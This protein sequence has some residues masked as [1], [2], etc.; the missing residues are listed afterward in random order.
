MARLT[1]LGPSVMQLHS[2]SLLKV[3]FQFPDFTSDSTF[4]LAVSGGIDSMVMLDLFAHLSQKQNIQFQVAHI[5]H[6]IRDESSTDARFVMNYCHELDIDCTVE[7]VDVSAEMD[8]SGESLEMCARRLRYEVL[9][10][11]AAIQNLD[12]IC[13][14]HNANDEAET[15]LMRILS[16][17]GITGLQ[18][19]RHM[20]GTIIRPLLRFTREQIE[21]HATRFDVPYRE[22]A[23]NADLSILRNRIR[24]SLLPLLEEEY[25]QSVVDALNRLSVAQTEV[26]ELLDHA[27]L[28][29]KSDVV[30]RQSTQEIMLDIHGLR[31]YFTAIQKAIIFNC[32]YELETDEIQ[33]NFEQTEQL[34]SMI[35]SAESGIEMLLPG[36]IR[37]VVDRNYL[38]F[39]TV[40]FRKQFAEPFQ[41]DAIQF[42]GRYRIAAET[43]SDLT[44][45]VLADSN[46]MIAYFEMISI[47]QIIEKCKIKP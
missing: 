20:R 27:A 17:T 36:N 37:A 31:T 44:G 6:G 46:E 10:S 7:A 25:N 38:Y 21:A 41:N 45:E 16:G 39:T 19:I 40:N 26:Q 22:D 9:E 13:T 28:Q 11:I 35:Q 2:A 30:I 32:L 42:L 43:L 12:L 1:K 5:E 3:L 14:A 23:T 33:L 47:F 4:L 24:H 15:I 34:T 29:A 18:G 8:I